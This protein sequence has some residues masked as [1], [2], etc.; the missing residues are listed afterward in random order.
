M[1]NYFHTKK[2]SINNI[3]RN[4][5]SSVLSLKNI[6]FVAFRSFKIWV[7]KSRRLRSMV[8]NLS[9]AARLV[10]LR[11]LMTSSRSSE[12]EINKWCAMLCAHD[13]RS[14]MVIMSK[15]PVK[16]SRFSSLG[17]NVW[18]YSSRRWGGTRRKSWRY[19][20]E[21]LSA[22]YTWVICFALLAFVSNRLLSNIERK[23]DF[24]FYYFDRE[25]HILIH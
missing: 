15:H 20:P 19:S 7:R 2:I 16:G 23:V 17:A 18:N 24:F 3:R 8:T 5:L 25:I 21:R 10:R 1:F 12:I 4:I 9:Q 22:W 6:V 11:S 14:E 13:S